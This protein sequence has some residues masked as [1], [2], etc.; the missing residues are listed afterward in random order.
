[1][2]F[3][4][5]SVP[6]TP[7]PRDAALAKEASDAEVLPFPAPG[8]T[9]RRFD[10]RPKKSF[11][12]N[13]I[14]EANVVEQIAAL[15][16]KENARV[17]E[18]GAGLGALTFAVLQRGHTVTA[19]ERDRDLIPVLQELGAAA[20]ATGRLKILEA[21]AK[22][23]DFAQEFDAMRATPSSATSSSATSSGAAEPRVLVGNVPYNLT[24]VLLRKATLLAKD[25]DLVLFLVQREV[26]DRL[27]A[28]PDSE[29]YGAL[30][31]FAQAAFRV[32]P[33]LHVGRRAFLPIP[34]VDSRVVVLEP[35]KPPRAEET[36]TF[37]ALVKAAFGQRR[38]TLRNAWKGLLGRSAAQIEAAASA[39]DVS[40]NAR[41]ET[42]S[43]EDF[44]RMSEQW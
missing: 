20:I 41:G 2:N 27:S 36:E 13:F 32:R 8:E 1:M 18:I 15:L 38:K 11:G 9:L 33:A 16:P 14:R 35:L 39:A 21:D 42:L 6:D 3:R 31:V 30:S 26:C 25:L 5:P 22:T 28:A 19:I 12:Q 29:H 4:I 24:G 44:R 37:R 34:N 43:V 17:L 23:A 10:L 40:L 7:V